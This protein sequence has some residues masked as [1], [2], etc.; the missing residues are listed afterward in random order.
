MAVGMRLHTVAAPVP[1]SP[2]KTIVIPTT[3]SSYEGKIT[4]QVYFPDSYASSAVERRYPVVINLHGGGFA[5]GTATDD[6]RW[7]RSVL[8]YTNAVV[9]SVDYR[10]APEFP[11]PTAVEDS[12]DAVLYIIQHASELK[13]DREKIA[14]SGF[15]AGGSLAFTVPLRL[16]EEYRL[17]ANTSTPVPPSQRGK[18]VSIASWY[19]ILD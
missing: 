5:M 13:V 16:A 10:L 2:S 18:I 8:L 7:T 4:L 19:P 11:F 17:R 6:A 15:S 9:V 3:I 14:L 1:P 12:V